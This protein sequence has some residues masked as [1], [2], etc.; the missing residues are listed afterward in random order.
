MTTT[1]EVTTTVYQICNDDRICEGE[2]NYRNCPGDCPSSSKDNYCDGIK[3]DTCDQ[4]CYRRSDPDCLC[5]RN[6]YCEEN[7]E[8]YENCPSDCPSGAKDG[9]CDRVK[10]GKCD[11][12]CNETDNDPDCIKIDPPSI[13][14]SIAIIILAFGALAYYNIRREMGNVKT[15]RNK[16]DLIDGLKERLRQGEDPETLKKELI[17]GGHDP[18]LLEKAEKGLWS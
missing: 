1:I 15:E 18:S 12:D 2:E 17:A 4:D 6:G 10:D 8:N 5:N 14:L 11:Q 9:Y 16:E 7:F 13:I 3:D